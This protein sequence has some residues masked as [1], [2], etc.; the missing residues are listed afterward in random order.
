MKEFYIARVA[1]A[2]TL[3]ELDYIVERASQD[4]DSQEDYE[5]VYGAAM[6]K[7]QRWRGF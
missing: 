7:A 2:R 1:E 5:A 4:L 3:D 6:D